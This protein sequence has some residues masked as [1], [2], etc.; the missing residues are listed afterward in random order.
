[1]V[2]RATLG[3]AR[4]ASG[5]G[6][7]DGSTLG[8]GPVN[9]ENALQSS[10]LPPGRSRLFYGWVIVTVSGIV[11]FTSTA[12]FNPVLSVFFGP[13]SDQFGWTR[14][15]MSLAVT[16]GSAV[17]AFASPGIGWTLDRWGGRWVMT[18]SALAMGGCL[19][20][21]SGMT[22]L[23]QYYVF[24]SIGRALAQGVINASVFISVANWFVRRRPFA[25][26]LVS[27]GQR[28]GLATLPLLAALVIGSGD[29][30]TGFTVLAVIV[31]AVGVLPPLLLMKRRPEDV[32]LLP[33][34]DAAPSED[35]DALSAAADVSWSLRDAVR[36]RAYWLIGFAIG[37]L[38]FCAGS[39][40]L[41]QIP[42]MVGNGLS[43]AEAAGIVAI[44]SIVAAGGGLLG[45]AIA[46]RLSTQRTI[47]LSLLGQAGGVVLLMAVDDLP[48]ALVYA[49]AYGLCFGTTVTL[50]QVIYA[51]YFGRLSLGVIRGSFQP[52]Q[53]AFNAAGPWLGGYWFDQTGSYTS[54][55]TLF[56]VLFVLASMFVALATVP[57]AAD[58][59]V[60]PDARA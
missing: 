29:W 14:G 60:A 19:F 1:M 33:D 53:L 55:F 32:G 25:V 24:Y 42:H 45:G 5:H 38:M 30:R 48:S 15:E 51:D 23:W 54:V 35:D 17:A 34:G 49:V 31:L 3:R 20:A 8:I 6:S 41:H 40:N 50:S 43:T 10:S 27:T 28:A 13:L 26:A 52:V 16:I 9:R 4:L 47:A 21:L 56:A 36:T 44:F 18:A 46:T 58:V 37:L 39:V 59:E 2:N 57:R 11:A 22:A 7:L 12:F